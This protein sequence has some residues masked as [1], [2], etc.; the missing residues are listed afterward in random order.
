MLP[1]VVIIQLYFC[2]SP[3]YLYTNYRIFPQICLDHMNV[4][5]LYLYTMPGYIAFTLHD[6]VQLLANNEL[7]HNH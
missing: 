5:T 3:M 1:L 6:G 7:T 2:L 4:Y